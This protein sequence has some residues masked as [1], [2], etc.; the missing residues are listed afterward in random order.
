MT[1]EEL[2]NLLLYGDIYEA[3]LSVLGDHFQEWREYDTEQL[4]R[5]SIAATLLAKGVCDDDL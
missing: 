5:M 1:S 2:I 4:V 3:P